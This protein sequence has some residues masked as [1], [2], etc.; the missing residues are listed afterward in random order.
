MKTVDSK[1]V[2]S[3]SIPQEERKREDFKEIPCKDMDLDCFALDGE[4]PF[5]DY[6][7]CYEYAP[8]MGK[9][10]FCISTKD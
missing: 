5:G 6:R 4:I 8:E 9:C 2:F 3:L 7:R 10:I 1:S